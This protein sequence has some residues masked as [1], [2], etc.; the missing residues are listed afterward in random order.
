M[1]TWICL[2]RGGVN[3]GARNRLAMVDL[4]D[5]LAD[6]GLVGARTYLQSGNVIV[7]VD[8][9]DPGRLVPR[10]R[11][12][13]HERFALDVPVIVRSP[14]WLTELLDWCP[15]RSSTARSCV[16]SESTERLGTGGHARHSRDSLTAAEEPE[17]PR[18]RFHAARAS[19]ER[20]RDNR[21]PPTPTQ[22]SPCRG[23]S[24]P[25]TT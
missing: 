20:C 9:P 10:V 14:E 5:A 1:S 17:E 7:D 11:T 4:R 6:I 19:P 3:L 21:C 22:S 2:L 8:E 24:V 12:V 23:G 16:A 25:L 18:P 13:I 15:F